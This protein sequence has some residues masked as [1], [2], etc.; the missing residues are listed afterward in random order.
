MVS[1]AASALARV[2]DEV[3]LLKVIVP[4]DQFWFISGTRFVLP[5]NVIVDVVELM[6]GTLPECQFAAVDHNSLAPPPFQS[7][8]APIDPGN[9]TSAKA[10][11]TPR[12]NLMGKRIFTCVLDV[13][14]TAAAK[15]QIAVK[16]PLNSMQA[17][18]TL[19]KS[20]LRA[21]DGVAH[22]VSGIPG[23]IR[24]LCGVTLNDSGDGWATLGNLG[25]HGSQ[26]RHR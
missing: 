18:D 6:A 7:I 8:W 9:A 5:L 15:A 16:S 22:G 10:L 23:P 17:P 19:R 12:I 2:N 11:S 4:T 3:L 25:A 14:Y 1:V 24:R 21:G 26:R 13:M 20:A